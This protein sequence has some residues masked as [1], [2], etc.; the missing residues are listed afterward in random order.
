MQFNSLVDSFT[1][2]P[3][4]HLSILSLLSLQS[5]RSHARLTSGLRNGPKHAFTSRVTPWFN[6]NLK[7]SEPS[8]GEG[9]PL[10]IRRRQGG[11]C[12]V[13]HW[14]QSSE[15]FTVSRA[16]YYPR[17]LAT[18]IDRARDRIM[19]YTPLQHHVSNT[20]LLSRRRPATFCNPGLRPEVSEHMNPGVV[21]P[22]HLFSRRWSRSVSGTTV[23]SV[24]CTVLAIDYVILFKAFACESK[25][26]A[27]FLHS[28]WKSSLRRNLVARTTY[29]QS[30]SGL[31]S[32]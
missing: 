30:Q 10:R 19:W 16:L 18:H 21:G 8:H 6:P 3:S 5:R 13:I 32:L 2:P 26:A 1:R 25:I 31:K 29:I 28:T 15:T 27:E 4:I 20:C 14:I 11:S 12:A 23:V 9:P 17:Q 7:H 24:H 22:S